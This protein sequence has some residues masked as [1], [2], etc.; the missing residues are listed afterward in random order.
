M[1]FAASTAAKAAARCGSVSTTPK[2]LV[3]IRLVLVSAI[4]LASVGSPSLPSGRPSSSVARSAAAAQAGKPGGRQRPVG[5]GLGDAAAGA[6]HGMGAGELV[7]RGAD[8]H[9]GVVEHEIVEV[10]QFAVEPQA[11]RGVGKVGAGDTAVADRA[12]GEPLVEPGQRILGG[13][14]RAGE[15]WPTAADRGSGSWIARS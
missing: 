13:G 2:R 1:A 7:G 14:E 8:V 11:G 3:G 6:Q 15:L 10:D 4:I 5:L 9:V 12:F